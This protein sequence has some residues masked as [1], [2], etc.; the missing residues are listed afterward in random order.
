MKIATA[1]SG[2]FGSIEFSMKYEDIEHEVVFACE[3]LDP[4]RKSYL[5]NH[6]EPTSNFYKD[7]R[8]LNGTKYKGEIDL[9]HLSPPCQSYSLA[10]NRGGAEDERGGLMFEAIKSIDE[11]QP[12]MFTIENVKGLL[13]SNGGDDWKNILR[14]VRS[15]KGYIVTWGV[16]NAKDQGT[17]QNR[18]RVFIV[19]FRGECMPM[20]FPL[21]KPRK[22]LKSIL[23]LEDYD[24]SLILPHNKYIKL[25]QDYAEVT[26]ATKSG[27]ET[28]ELY[29]SIVNSH[30]GS[31]T[32]RGRIG[33]AQSQTLT[34]SKSMCVLIKHNGKLAV[35][36]L[37][38]RE[39]ARVQGDFQDMFKQGEASDTKLYEFIGNA[40]DIST[41]RNLLKA[42]FA[43]KVE[44]REP[45]EPSFIR[46]EVKEMTLF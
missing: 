36:Y 17:P 14:D 1:F 46:R 13:S 27:Y 21:I 16:M 20:P 24:I 18:E 34:T 4:Q 30:L 38:T 9:Y 40:M 28:A 39:Y 15:L 25:H 2:G 19:G 3:W 10:G 45:L 11:V 32:G 5:H 41:T 33:T 31:K 12:K 22:L 23:E 8:D 37:S 26:S 29:D 6:G 35:R 43:H 44:F 7:I 42:M